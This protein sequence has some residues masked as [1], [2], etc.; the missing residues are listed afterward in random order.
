LNASEPINYADVVKCKPNL[1]MDSEI[2]PPLQGTAAMPL[3]GTAAMQLQGIAA[4]FGR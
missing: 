4:I 2:L 1:K 3:Q